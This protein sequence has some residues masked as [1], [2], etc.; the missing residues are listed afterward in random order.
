[1]AAG[2]ASVP[3]A[4]A[5]NAE[6]VSKLLR[7]SGSSFIFVDL[8]HLPIV[9]AAVKGTSAKIIL[10]D[11]SGKGPIPELTRMFAAGPGELQPARGDDTDPAVMLHNTRPTSD[12]QGLS[13]C[14]R[15]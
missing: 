15:H 7:D 6:Q 12:P 5:F 4:T 10:L 8:R 1:M 11:G 9:D 14:H 13:L 3:H 2:G